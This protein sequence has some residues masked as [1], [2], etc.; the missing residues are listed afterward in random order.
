MKWL[1]KD[2]VK[3]LLKWNVKIATVELVAKAIFNYFRIHATD[4]RLN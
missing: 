2:F 4:V 1:F 3:H